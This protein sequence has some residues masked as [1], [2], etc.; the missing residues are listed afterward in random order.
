MAFDFDVDAWEDYNGDR[1]AGK[2]SDLSD[3]WGVR[4]IAADTETGETHIFWAFTP[5]PYEDWEEWLDHIGILMSMH[6]M[7]LA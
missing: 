2:P 1:H 6:G 4:V 7:E 3:T 5:S